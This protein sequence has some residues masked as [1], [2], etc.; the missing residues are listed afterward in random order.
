MSWVGSGHETSKDQAYTYAYCVQRVEEEFTWFACWKKKHGCLLSKLVL[1]GV[2][3]QS[4][5][6]RATKFLGHDHKS[7]V[8]S[9]FPSNVPH[10][11]NGLFLGALTTGGEYQVELLSE[12]RL[13]TLYF[14]N[15]PSKFRMIKRTG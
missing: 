3:E 14:P 10:G 6:K 15:N 4:R 7:S 8:G 13:S 9:I 12:L 2:L 5:M 1:R 11:V